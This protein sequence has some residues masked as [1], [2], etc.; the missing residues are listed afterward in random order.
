MNIQARLLLLYPNTNSTPY[1]Q[2]KVY[3][4]QFFFHYCPYLLL[5]EN[6]DN[7]F[8]VREGKGKKWNVFKQGKG[9]EKNGMQWNLVTLIGCFKI[10]E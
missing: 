1:S 8:F 9:M 10:K 5:D 3:K 2:L 7:S 4:T 6:L